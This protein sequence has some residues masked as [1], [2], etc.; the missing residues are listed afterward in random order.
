[1]KCV[2]MTY[3]ECQNEPSKPE[4]KLRDVTEDNATEIAREYLDSDGREELEFKIEDQEQ[5]ADIAVTDGEGSWVLFT[6]VEL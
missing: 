5:Y 6:K 1:M 2:V 4:S 3:L